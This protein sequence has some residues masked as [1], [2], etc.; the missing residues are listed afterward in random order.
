MSEPRLVSAYSC[1]SVKDP[2]EM[3]AVALIGIEEI[4][5]AELPED[6]PHDQFFNT[7]FMLPVIH[8]LGLKNIKGETPESVII[9]AANAL[10]DKRLFLVEDKQMMVDIELIGPELVN[11]A[12]I[13]YLANM[14]LLGGRR[15]SYD[16]VD[17]VYTVPIREI[18]SS[19]ISIFGR[20]GIKIADC[21]LAD[22]LQQQLFSLSLGQE[23][24]ETLLFA[25]GMGVWKIMLEY[26]RGA[27]YYDH[28]QSMKQEDYDWANEGLNG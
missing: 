6:Q 9:R 18:V 13:G 24:L 14:V 20:D 15:V 12:P 8:V 21:D 19:L 27:M 3:S 22:G 7:E 17:G 1:V 16:D 5:T 4:K 11:D 23:E 26:K 25:V 10:D 2:E 28:K